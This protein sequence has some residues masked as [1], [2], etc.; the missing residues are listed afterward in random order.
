MD[1]LALKVAMTCKEK[2]ADEVAKAIGI[3]R[4]WFNKKRFGEH[5]FTNIEIGALAKVLELSLDDVNRIFFDNELQNSKICPYAE[6][7]ISNVKNND[8]GG[9]EYG[10]QANVS[11][12]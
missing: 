7:I 3:S 4:V 6:S 8:G 12:G 11:N 1:I 2:S 5:P 10:N 9:D